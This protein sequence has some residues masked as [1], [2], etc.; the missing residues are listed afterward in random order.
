MN[1]KVNS[2][3]IAFKRFLNDKELLGDIRTGVAITLALLL[4]LAWFGLF[5]NVD[6]YALLN[7]T[8]GGLVLFVVASLVISWV[9]ISIKA[10]RDEIENNKELQ[11]TMKSTYEKQTK[12]PKVDEVIKFNNLYNYEKQINRDMMLNE[13]IRKSLQNKIDH[14][15]IKGKSYKKHERKLN[16]LDSKPMVDTTYKPIKVENII[17]QVGAPKQ[18]VDGNDSIIYNPVSDGFIRFL[19]MQPFKGFGLGGIGSA[20]ILSLGYSW[21]TIIVFYV[22]FILMWLMTVIPRYLRVRFN[23]STKYLKTYINIGKYID[24][25]YEWYNLKEK[26]ESIPLVLN[27]EVGE[28]AKKEINEAFDNIIVNEVKEKALD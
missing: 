11:A 2:F 24:E 27:E 16:R 10:K 6:I 3:N 9:E 15:K 22:G 21:W 8:V 5:A 19:F 26:G 4:P 17:N 18:D 28:L 12:L 20:F 14:C 23:T 7:Y 13:K 1:D 25:F